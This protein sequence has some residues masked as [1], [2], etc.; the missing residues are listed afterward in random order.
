MP[1]VLA[2]R[3]D[4][5]VHLDRDT[6]LGEPKL[7][8]QLRDRNVTIETARFTIHLNLHG[9]RR[10]EDSTTAHTIFDRPI[11]AKALTGA[12]VTT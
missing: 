10:A 4:L 8:Q 2:A 3:H 12:D 7:G 6:A 5:A 11:T 1:R 9:Q